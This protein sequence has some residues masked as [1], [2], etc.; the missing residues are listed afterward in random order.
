MAEVAGGAESARQATLRETLW[1]GIR[2]LYEG[3]IRNAA[4]APVIA[5]TLNVS[6]PGC[7]GETLL[8]G[9]DLEGVAVSSGSACMV[10]SVLPSHVLLAMGAPEETAR[11]TVRFSLGRET[12]PEE[13]ATTI[14]AL[15]RV[16]ARQGI[17]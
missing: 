9:L 8:M 14:A 6:F 10:G 1:T 5:N 17:R 3:A 4:G 15:G 2:N 7:D 11:A 13:I 12:T 16:L